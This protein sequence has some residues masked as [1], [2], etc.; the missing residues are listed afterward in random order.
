MSWGEEILR[1]LFLVLGSFEVITSL[2]YLIRKGG[3]NHARKQHSELPQNLPDNKI[4]IKVICMLISGMALFIVALV[5]YLLH[6]YISEAFVCTA[7][8]FAIY[9]AV[10]AFYY[11]YWKTFG[12]WFVTLILFAAALLNHLL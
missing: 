3:L 12:F 6:S 7:G 10:E 11:R 9:G 1:A 8:L 4:K 5:S 2:T